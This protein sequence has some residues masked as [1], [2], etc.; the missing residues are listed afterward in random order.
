MQMWKDRVSS[1]AHATHDLT[2]PHAI[3]RSHGYTASLHMHKQ[4]VLAVLVINQDA[5]PD[6]FR[7]LASRKFWM[8]DLDRK[9]V[10]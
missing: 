1:E 9:S 2:L 4:A 3:T 7:V 10:V 8:P 5:V 6:V